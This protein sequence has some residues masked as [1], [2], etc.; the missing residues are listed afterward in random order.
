V[1]GSHRSAVAVGARKVASRMHDTTVIIPASPEQ[2]FAKEPSRFTWRA[3][4]STANLRAAFPALKESSEGLVS[5]G[6]H[7]PESG[8]SSYL[9]IVRCDGDG[10]PSCADGGKAQVRASKFPC[11]L[12]RV[13]CLLIPDSVAGTRR[14]SE[15]AIRTPAQITREHA[16]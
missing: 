8:N 7:T 2:E 13:A 3:R 11:D 9:G 6:L 15:E 16:E 12:H 10:G 5:V 4:D 14:R 1:D